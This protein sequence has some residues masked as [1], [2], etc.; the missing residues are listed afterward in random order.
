MDLKIRNHTDMTG[1]YRAERA[2]G[3]YNVELELGTTFEA[4][5]QVP[6]WTEMGPDGEDWTIGVV[7]GPSGSGKTSIGRSL[8]SMWE[9]VAW[10][11][12]RPIVEAITPDGTF[13]DTTAALAA[14]GLG[15]VPSWLRPYPV[16]SNGE[17]FRA[18]LARII[19]EKP[20]R[21]VID[22]F[23]SVVD[24]Q[25]AQ[26]GAGAFAKSWKRGN[27]GE[28]KAVLLTCHY[29]ILDWVNPDWILDT[30]SGELSWP[31]GSLQRRP[32][33]LEVVE[34]KWA[35]WPY[36]KPHHYLSDAGPMPF[37]TAFVAFV[38]DEPVAHLGMS[39]MTVGKGK[40]EARACRMVVMPE[41]QGAGVGMRFLNTMCQREL[42]GEGFVGFRST[43]LFHTNHPALANAL[44]R[45]RHWRQLSYK[46]YG[47]NRG[48]SQ[49]SLMRTSKRKR[50]TGA[51]MDKLGWGG[52]FRGVQGFRFGGERY[53]NAW[54]L[55]HRCS[56]CGVEAAR[57]PMGKK[58]VLFKCG[59]CGAE[60][61]KTEN[62]AANQ[63][64]LG[65]TV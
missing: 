41:W 56:V 30:S 12:D 2:R 17:Q 24:R 53:V 3:L 22:E 25:V 13:D 37:S 63:L 58:D 54:K 44:R 34:V 7:V 18:N 64:Q 6:D 42:D 50:E 65:I 14:V 29:D 36:F 35:Y 11:D 10:P 43:T 55:T 38:D 31:R 26:V 27:K 57:V 48:K 15:D 51:S 39:A 5:F 20:E 40:R 49:E 28:R 62:F 46:L 21:V 1:G 8:D 33:H 47:S 16:L 4:E 23:T 60:I 59:A 19:A 9:N 32:I 61:P 52:H 45:D